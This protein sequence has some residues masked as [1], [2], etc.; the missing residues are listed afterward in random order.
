VGRPSSLQVSEHPLIGF[1]LLLWGVGIVLFAFKLQTNIQKAA[2]PEWQYAR[3]LYDQAP[4]LFC[5]L[6]ALALALW[7]V[8]LV[9]LLYKTYVKG[10]THGN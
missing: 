7:P 5:T 3:D 9:Y 2:E 8:I 1:L 10:S 6:N 4:I